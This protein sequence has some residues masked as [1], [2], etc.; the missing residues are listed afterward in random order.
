M[1]LLTLFRFLFEVVGKGGT[2]V[3]PQSGMFIRGLLFLSFHTESN[4]VIDVDCHLVQIFLFGPF[5]AL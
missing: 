5:E 3:Q 4:R 1:E 2:I